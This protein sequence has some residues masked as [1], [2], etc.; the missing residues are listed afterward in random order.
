MN[1][2]KKPEPE[3]HKIGSNIFVR[4]LRKIVKVQL[5]WEGHNNLRNLPYG[6]DNYLVNVKTIRQI[7]QTF[8]AFSEKLNFKIT[9]SEA[10]K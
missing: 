8:V 6:F 5:F 2:Y 9:E 7:V 4:L 3:P 10:S 1:F